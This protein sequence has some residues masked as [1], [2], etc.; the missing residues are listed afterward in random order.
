MGKEALQPP[1]AAALVGTDCFLQLSALAEVL[2]LLGNAQKVELDGETAELADAL[3][4]VRSF[5]MFGDA[6]AV[7]IRNADSFVTKYREQLENYLAAPADSAM[8]ILRLNSLPSNQRIYKAIEK[9]GRVISCEAPKDP[10][11][12]IIDHGRSAHKLNIAPDAARML[13][14][15]VGNDLGRLDNELAKLSL[16]HGGAVGVREVEAAVAFQRERQMWDLTNA[17]AC[18]DRAAALRRWR[19]LVQLDSSAEFRAVTWLGLWLENVRKALAMLARGESAIAIGQALRIWPRELQQP[20]VQTARAMGRRGLD[21]A[22]NLLAEIDFQTK[23][24]IGDAADNVERFILTL[25]LAG[26]LPTPP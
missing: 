13:A 5:S 19:Q 8:L 20:F 10:T 15:L 2:S 26:E 14:D 25:A 12:W 11:R 24:G 16:I 9:I 18:G 1:R 6:K 21:R 22:L 17:L 3:D 23:T 4:E 7:M